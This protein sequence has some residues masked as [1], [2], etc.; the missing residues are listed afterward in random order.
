MSEKGAV[1]QE[2]MLPELR[3]SVFTYK[4][5]GNWRRRQRNSES[6]IL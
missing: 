1:V 2:M 6:K 3:S 4:A 5:L